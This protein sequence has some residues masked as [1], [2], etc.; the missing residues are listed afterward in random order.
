LQDTVQ[1]EQTDVNDSQYNKI[2]D[3]AAKA[4]KTFREKI[5]E[6]AKRLES[7]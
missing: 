6:A 1:Q 7:L 5:L 3:D 4:T 2:L